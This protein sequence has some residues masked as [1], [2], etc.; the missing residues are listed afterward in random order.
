MTFIFA[1]KLSAAYSMELYFHENH[2]KASRQAV[3][4]PIS[5][6]EAGG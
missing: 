5:L 6:Q 2:M 4:C 3:K 1:S